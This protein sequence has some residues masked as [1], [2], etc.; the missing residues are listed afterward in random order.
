MTNEPQRDTRVTIADVANLAEILKAA[1][2]N[3]RLARLIEDVRYDGVARR[4]CDP[5]GGSA[6]GTGTDIRDLCLEVL[7]DGVGAT[8]LWPVRELMA[9]LVSGH[10]VPLASHEE[11]QPA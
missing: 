9:E 10:F 3:Q 6:V 11:E 5:C 4:I 8:V 1:Q 7:L 2:C